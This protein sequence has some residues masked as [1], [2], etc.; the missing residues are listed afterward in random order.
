MQ[1]IYNDLEVQ[2]TL[3]TYF[4]KIIKPLYAN[5]ETNKKWPTF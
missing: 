3:K 1:K 4:Q 5:N 2:F